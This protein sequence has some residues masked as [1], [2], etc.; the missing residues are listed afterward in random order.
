[1]RTAIRPNMGAKLSLSTLFMMGTMMMSYSMTASAQFDPCDPSNPSTYDPSLCNSGGGGTGTSDSDMCDDGL[2]DPLTCGGDVCSVSE[3]YYDPGMCEA[4]CT[5]QGSQGMLGMAWA[6]C[7][8]EMVCNPDSHFF[9]AIQCGACA[10]EDAPLLPAGPSNAQFTFSQNA[11]EVCIENVFWIDPPVST[12]F[13]YSV[14]GSQFEKVQMPSSAYVPDP[15]GYTLEYVESGITQVISLGSGAVYEFASPV[16]EFTITGINLELELDPADTMAFRTG[17]DL[18]PTNTGVTITQTPITQNY[19]PPNNPPTA[20]AGPDQTILG[21][22]YIEIDGS[23]SSDPDGDSLTYHWSQV[24]GPIVALTDEHTATPSLFAPNVT[25]LTTL[26]FELKVEDSNGEMSSPD[27]V[28]LNVS[29][30]AGLDQCTPWNRDRLVEAIEFYPEAGGYSVTQNITGQIETDLQNWVNNIDLTQYPDFGKFE[31]KSYV[32]NVG[33]GETPQLI[34]PQMPDM[35]PSSRFFTVP[36]SAAPAPY[37]TGG[38]FQADNWYRLDTKINVYRASN[39]H[40]YSDLP[41][42]S[43]YDDKC[44]YQTVYFK[45]NAQGNI[46]AR[47]RGDRVRRTPLPLPPR[48]IFSD[49][50]QAIGSVKFPTRPRP[51]DIKNPRGLVPT[52]R[53]PGRPVK[54]PVRGR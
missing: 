19:V 47:Q 50:T 52:G 43:A 24:S 23:G 16:T 28:E 14:A 32:K 8:P 37:W 9:D 45:I 35:P 25:T 34:G 12:G 21:P 42:T 51:R 15:D 40:F 33:T 1:M 2:G 22:H 38:N 36:A 3:T 49:G 54:P 29:P 26:I 44:V 7:G 11:G 10:P 4:A 17:I 13:D 31:I 48:M 46:Q 27:Q 39:G 41:M 30:L 18:A 6:T 5:D 20:D 53:P